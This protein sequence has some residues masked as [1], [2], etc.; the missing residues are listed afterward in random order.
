MN[1]E[2]EPNALLADVAGEGTDF[3]AA[4]LAQTLRAVR[5]R[6]QWRQ[7]RALAVILLLAGVVGTAGL[8]VYRRSAPVLSTPPLAQTP[9]PYELV[10]TRPF[11]ADAIVRST[12]FA[13]A[14]A[15]TIPVTLVQTTT[16][17]G[18]FRLLNDEE[19]LAL[20]AARP[21]ILIRLAGHSEQL[22]FLDQ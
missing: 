12:P 5:R 8:L 10:Q 9:P 7:A 2:A 4:L 6:Q 16:T 1:P 20:A 21:V 17:S 13:A 18:G 19:L 15:E 3:R 22:I 11:P 14:W